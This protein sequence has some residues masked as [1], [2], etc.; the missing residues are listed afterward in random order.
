MPWLSRHLSVPCLGETVASSAQLFSYPLLSP[1]NGQ[2][3]ARSFYN[4]DW[5]WDLQAPRPA[6]TCKKNRKP[7]PSLLE[8]ELKNTVSPGRQA[9]RQAGQ[10]PHCLSEAGPT[11]GRTP[12]GVANGSLVNFL[13]PAPPFCSLL[14]TVHRVVRIV[15]VL[16][17]WPL[18]P[19]V[20]RKKAKFL[21][22]GG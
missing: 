11:S 6:G 20:H 9:G 13:S 5:S 3:P 8:R 18:A 12:H 10:A 17:K 21:P 7:S 15:C 19:C 2:L 4:L 1:M 16:K 14:C 22:K